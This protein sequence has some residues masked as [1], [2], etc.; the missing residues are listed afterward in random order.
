MMAGAATLKGVNYLSLCSTG[1]P[2]LVAQ[3]PLP[4]QVF[5]PAQPASPVLQPPLPLQEFLPAQ[6]CVSPFSFFFFSSSSK[7]RFDL[8][9]LAPV[10]AAFA[11][12]RKPPVMMPASAA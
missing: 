7:P 9:K 5:L 8:L 10:E 3:P 4:L 6:S 2:S 11:F 12:A 1:L